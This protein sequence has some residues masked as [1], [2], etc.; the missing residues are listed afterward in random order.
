M[1]LW[2]IKLLHKLYV[3]KLYILGA[4][5]IG[6]K[7]AEMRRFSSRRKKRTLII[8]KNKKNVLP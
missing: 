5:G 3:N 6:G 8:K 7:G 4:L 2:G 1:G